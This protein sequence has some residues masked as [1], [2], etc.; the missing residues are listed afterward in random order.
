MA[1]GERA[2][3]KTHVGARQVSPWAVLGTVDVTFVGGRL[4][5]EGDR[6]ERA[7]KNGGRDE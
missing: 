3:E 1:P 7:R 2:A 5:G 6:A 4:V